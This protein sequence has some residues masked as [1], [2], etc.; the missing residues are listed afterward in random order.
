MRGINMRTA[1]KPWGPW[2]EPEIIF[3]P[4]W[5]NGYC[6]FMHTNNEFLQCDNVSDEERENLWGEEYGPYQFEDF[7]IGDAC[8]TT[9]YF[10]LSIWNPYTVVLM[11]AALE[12]I[13]RMMIHGLVNGLLR[14]CFCQMN[15]TA[16]WN[17]L[18]ERGL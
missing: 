18:V 16:R 14:H 12:R 15:R 5:D 3:H 7:A 13:S 6:H 1:D 11:K 4:W 2:S 8:S 10:T 17:C 9:I